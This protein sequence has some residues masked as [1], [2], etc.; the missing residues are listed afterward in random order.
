[1]FS[2]RLV[3]L[4]VRLQ[5]KL[6][7]QKSL[8]KESLWQEE[9]LCVCVRACVRARVC[10]CVCVCALTVVCSCELVCSGCSSSKHKVSR[11]TAAFSKLFLE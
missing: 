6:F 9:L 1:M 4:E 11:A 10:V 5:G 8:P 2:T 7:G 3:F